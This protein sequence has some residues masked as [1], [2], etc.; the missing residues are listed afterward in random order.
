MTLSEVQQAFQQ[1]MKQSPPEL[2]NQFDP[3]VWLWVSGI[4]SGITI[5]VSIVSGSMSWQFIRGRLLAALMIGVFLSTFCTAIYSSLAASSLFRDEQSAYVQH[6]KQ[7]LQTW[8]TN[9]AEPY[10]SSLPVHKNKML[11]LTIHPVTESET[12]DMQMSMNDAVEGTS[13]TSTSL[14]V[15]YKDEKG[16]VVTR[17]D[18]MV[19]KMDLAAGADPYVSYVTLPEPLDTL[20][21]AQKSAFKK[22]RGTINGAADDLQIISQERYPAGHYTYQIHLPSDYDYAT[23]LEKQSPS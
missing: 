21:A 23:L 12:D 7:Q 4:I 6:M 15:I 1:I 9:M 22:L 8:Q 19:I 16:E 10:I 18:D 11:H 14:I 2:E 17:K 5:L 3:H 20:T 13:G